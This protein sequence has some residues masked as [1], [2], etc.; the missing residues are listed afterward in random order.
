VVPH[1][2]KWAVD[3][4]IQTQLRKL[5][6]LFRSNAFLYLQLSENMHSAWWCYSYVIIQNENNI[7]KD[8]SFILSEKCAFN[9]NWERENRY[10]NVNQSWNLI[11]ILLIRKKWRPFKRKGL[12][13]KLTHALWFLIVVFLLLLINLISMFKNIMIIYRLLL[14]LNKVIHCILNDLFDV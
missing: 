8:Y 14:L 9:W 1:M 2:Y 13:I 6:R 7:G 12:W 10:Q 11:S 4:T 3:S 5:A